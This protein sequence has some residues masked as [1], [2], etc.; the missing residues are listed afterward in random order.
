MSL[1]NG[2]IANL[3]VARKSLKGSN[4]KKLRRRAFGSP[5]RADKSGFALRRKRGDDGKRWK[6][7]KIKSRHLEGAGVSWKRNCS[8]YLA[9]T[10]WPVY[11]WM[12]A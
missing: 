2:S 11:F 1:P 7:M 5:S 10:R 9:A 3:S 12:L 6:R 4:E 8:P